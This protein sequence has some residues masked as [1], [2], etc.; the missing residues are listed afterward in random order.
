MAADAFVIPPNRLG[1]R[2]RV[3]P[4]HGRRRRVLLA[5][6]NQLAA[7]PARI[8]ANGVATGWPLADGRAQQRDGLPDAAVVHHPLWIGADG[9]HFLLA[10]VVSVG[11]ARRISVLPSTQ[12]LHGL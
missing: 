10:G 11:G 1:D 6:P 2:G 5:P 3:P 4:G 8:A 7:I 9:R 12:L